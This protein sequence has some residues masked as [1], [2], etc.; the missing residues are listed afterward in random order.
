MSAVE[1]LANAMVQNMLLQTLEAVLTRELER[2]ASHSLR[3][4]E[5]CVGILANVATFSNLASA[6]AGSAELLQILFE[7]VRFGRSTGVW[8]ETCNNNSSTV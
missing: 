4:V 5:I 1:P 3:L 7:Q 8:L 6:L 2:G